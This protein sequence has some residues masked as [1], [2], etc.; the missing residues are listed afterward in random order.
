MD[1]QKYVILTQEDTISKIT[2]RA[3]V[4][5]ILVGVTD[6]KEYTTYIDSTNHNVKNWYHITNNPTHGFIL[7]GLRTKTHKGKDLID[8]DSKPIICAED[9][10]QSKVLDILKEVWREQDRKDTTVFRTLFE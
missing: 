5:I 6:R 7:K 3:C 10:S 8:A 2:G 1:K 9:E 4:K